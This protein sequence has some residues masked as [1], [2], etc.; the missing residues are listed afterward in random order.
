[1]A[2]TTLAGVAIGASPASAGD[3][4]DRAARI[5]E[6]TVEI[7][8][9][10]PAD[11]TLQTPVWVGAHDGSFDLYDR[12]A[13]ISPEL[14]RLAEDG[15]TGPITELFADS[16]AG[17]D[18][19]STGGPF[20]GGETR[21]AT[22]LVDTTRGESQYFSYASMVIPSNDAFVANG[23][24]TAHKIFNDR[25]RFMPVSFIVSGGEVLDAGSEV[26]DEIPENT[27]ALAQSAPDTGVTENGVVTLHEGFQPGG[28]ILAARPGGDFTADGYQAL[29]IDVTAHRLNSR[30]AAALRGNLEVPPV[31]TQ[32]SGIVRMVLEEDG[33]IDWSMNARRIDGVVAAHIHIGQPDEN[34]PV[35][36]LLFSSDPTAGP[37]L[38]ASGEL[39]D[40]DMTG[41]F[42]GMT[43][44]DLWMAIQ[45]GHAY[46]NVHTLDVP[47]GELRANLP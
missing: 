45:A 41:P 47:S 2:A 35:A 39:T 42:A 14:E 23:N 33:D 27:A 20:A 25:G 37:G 12:G 34:G 7:T 30:A 26:N 21:T 43:T 32:A 40:A 9:L 16:G 1:M 28:N 24:P 29:Q 13:P 18:S 15:N 4:P 44:L 10:A 5:F 19:T 22:F 31:S 8:N 11:G 46:V 6:V 17:T 3:P 36:A 38:Q